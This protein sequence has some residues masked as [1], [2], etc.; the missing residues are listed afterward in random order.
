[1][2][3]YKYLDL[4]TSHLPETEMR[5]IDETSADSLLCGSRVIP[6]NYGA[7]VHVP[8]KNAESFDDDEERALGYPNLHACIEYARKY[9]ATWINFDSDGDVESEL[10]VHFW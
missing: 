3:V 9:E 6:H 5:S 1:M 8:E 4:S 7:W 2:G 10:P